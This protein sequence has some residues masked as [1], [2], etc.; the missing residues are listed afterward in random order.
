MNQEVRTTAHIIRRGRIELVRIRISFISEHTTKGVSASRKRSA[1][2]DASVSRIVAAAVVDRTRAG[3]T[4]I[5]PG[6][7]ICSPRETMGA[8][9]ISIRTPGGGV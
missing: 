1:V 2:F 3:T 7:I 5:D 8:N 4:G 9:V 6:A